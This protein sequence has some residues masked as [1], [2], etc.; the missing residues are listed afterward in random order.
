MHMPLGF[1]CRSCG[2]VYY[3]VQDG[4]G[5]KL[6]DCRNESIPPLD[7][8]PSSKN[9]QPISHQGEDDKLFTYEAA[10]PVLISKVFEKW[11]A[12]IPSTITGQDFESLVKAVMR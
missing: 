4:V 8:H 1:I 9:A 12:Q 2:C 5:W 6:Y 3:H 10:H 11:W 7:Y